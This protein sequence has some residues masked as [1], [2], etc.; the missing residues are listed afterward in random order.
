V[1]LHYVYEFMDKLL[2]LLGDVT[3][4]F[5]R[6]PGAIM[7]PKRIRVVDDSEELHLHM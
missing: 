3:A 5:K 6:F 2:E 7:G 1:F 4:E